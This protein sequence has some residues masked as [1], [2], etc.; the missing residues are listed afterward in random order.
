[1][2][3]TMALGATER[4]HRFVAGL[5]GWRAGLLAVVLGALSALAMAPFYAFPILAVTLT[6]CVWLIDGAQRQARPLGAA[7]WRGWAFGFGFFLAGFYWIGYSFLVR[8][9][10]HLWLLPFAAALFPGGLALFFSV[11]FWGAAFAWREG[12]QRV[13]VFSFAVSATE[14]LRGHILTGFPWNLFG[15]T[16]GGIDATMQFASIVGVY[17][18]TLLTLLAMAAPAALM[19]RDSSLQVNAIYGVLAVIILP[20]FL[21]AFGWFRLPSGPQPAL[22]GAKIRIVQ[23]NVPQTEKWLPELGIRNWQRLIEP[24][25]LNGQQ[26]Y[27]YAI[28]PEAAAPFILREHSE[29]LRMIGLSLPKGAALL[30]GAAYREETDGRTRYFNGMHV[31]DETG[32]VIETYA[33]SHLVPFGEYLPFAWVL[34]RLGVTKIT[35]GTGGYS[36]GAGVRSITIRSNGGQKTT[37]GPL[38]CYEILFP[39]FVV[40]PGRRPEWLVNMTDDSWFGPSTGPYQHL[41]ISRMRAVEE[42]LS[43]VRAANTGISA[44]IDPY[45]RV[46]ASLP[47]GSQ[48]VIDGFV[49]RPLAKTSYA[50][51]GSVLYTFAM[52]ALAVWI[53]WGL[54]HRLSGVANPIG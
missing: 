36:S 42:G 48:G 16:W 40:E 1:M 23:P 9:D 31:I 6:G 49:P 26:P 50:A 54:R 14:W 2:R 53:A 20:M 24:L 38:I 11:A 44:I 10:A 22:E 29:A 32:S 37:F 5:S 17:G 8:P 25:A 51:W 43:V 19:R 30:A 15:Y 34:E 4:S 21:F 35:G 7:A 28:W 3:F 52:A 46:V 41:G 12:W 13:L 47:L 45:G 27:N 33:K 18:L 39:N